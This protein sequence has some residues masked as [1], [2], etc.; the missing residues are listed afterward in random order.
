MSPL[1]ATKISFIMGFIVFVS[2]HRVTAPQYGEGRNI[3]I[4]RLRYSANH[5]APDSWPIRARLA[6]QNDEL[7]KNQP[8]SERQR[9]NNNV[10]YVKI[11]VFLNFKPH[12][13]ITPNTQNNLLFSSVIWPPLIKGLDVLILP[14]WDRR[15]QKW[16]IPRVQSVLRNRRCMTDPESQREVLRP[17]DSP[18]RRPRTDAVHHWSKCWSAERVTGWAPKLKHGTSA[19]TQ[20]ISISQ[21]QA[22]LGFKE[23]EGHMQKWA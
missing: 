9:S 6:S 20:C 19:L 3:S 12:K 14:W 17:A 13:H 11:N 4:S 16:P 15:W 8:V 18:L 1:D 5:N 7:C 22:R 23:P 21:T 2:S 10:Q